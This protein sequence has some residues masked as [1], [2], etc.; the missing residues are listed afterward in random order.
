M[1]PQYYQY[2]SLIADSYEEYAINSGRNGIL[3]HSN[4]ALDGFD[5]ILET[6]EETLN[7]VR[8]TRERPTGGGSSERIVA[9]AEGGEEGVAPRI[10]IEGDIELQEVLEELFGDGRGTNL[11]ERYIRECLGCNLRFRFNWEFKPLDLIPNLKAIFD[12]IKASLDAFRERLDPMRALAGICN[13]L[14]AFRGFCIPDI[15]AFILA[16]KML[17][18]KYLTNSLK[19][20]FD[21]TSLIGPLI[22]ALSHAIS[23]LLN[24]VAAFIVAPLECFQA[25]LRTANNL[26]KE[27]RNIASLVDSL[28]TNPQQIDASGSG[29]LNTSV[30]ADR[31]AFNIDINANATGSGFDVRQSETPLNELDTTTVSEPPFTGPLQEGESPERGDGFVTGFDID[32]VQTVKD[33]LKDPKFIDSTFIEKA[34]LPLKEAIAYIQKLAASINQL[35]KSMDALVGSGLSLNLESLGVVLFIL[36]MISLVTIIVR[37]INSN[38]SV[39]DW[40][41]ELEE[42]PRA[43][44]NVLNEATIRRRFGISVEDSFTLTRGDQKLILSLGNEVV[45]NISTCATD[46]ADNNV[47]RTWIREIEDRISL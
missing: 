9:T 11:A 13:L 16:L 34:M 21:W 36:D 32:L 35:I 12:K 8:D 23:S 17:L 42:R 7:G 4:R 31:G 3:A 40:C 2:L 28:V 5:Q 43:L 47:L 24:N 41:S 10:A 38:R 1:H 29:V 46:R 19:I 33:A 30:S 14:N 15:I 26:E 25:V 18:K 45:A 37:M 44:E 39:N 20:K 22:R 6:S 27:V